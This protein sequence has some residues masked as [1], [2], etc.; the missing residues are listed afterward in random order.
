[1]K[2]ASNEYYDSLIKKTEEFYDK[3]IDTLDKTK[4]RWQELA[5]LKEEAEMKQ[6][7][8][9]VLNQYGIT[10]NDIVNMS[11]EAFN[12]FKND[13]L[14]ILS[15][16]YSGNEQMQSAIADTAGTTTEKLGS[17]IASTQEYIDSLNGCS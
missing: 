10:A 4:S 7:M 15:D 8:E 14:N 2:D 13:Y 12:A 11:E 6:K 3:L 1:M 17:Y 5:D 16:L 9:E